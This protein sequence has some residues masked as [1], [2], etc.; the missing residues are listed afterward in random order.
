MA[1]DGI[2]LHHLQKEILQKAQNAKVDKIYQ[3]NREE[4]VLSLRTRYDTYKLLFSARANS[5]RVHFTT[6]TIENPK[7]P[8]MFCMLLRKR[9]TSAK[10]VQI[11]QNDLERVL[12]FDFDAYNELGDLIR[13]TLVCEIMG[14]YSNVIFLDGEEKIIDS[15]KRVDEEMTSERLVLP[16]LPYRL[17]P[18][19]NKLSLLCHQP[20]EVLSVM[21]SSVKN[22]ELVNLLLDT[23]Q[24]VSPVVCRELEHRIG[25]GSSKLIRELSPLQERALLQELE[26]LKQ[27]AEQVN[28]TPCMI[29]DPVT[30]KPM[31]FS[32][33]PIGQYGDFAQISM[34]DSFS[35]LLDSFYRERDRIERMK[36]KTQGLH[37]ILA[38][39]AE[40]LS[41]KINLQQG[42]LQRCT[43]REHLKICGDL[44]SANLYQ[45]QKGESTVSLCNFYEEEQPQ[46]TISLDPLLTPSQ[47]AQKYYKEYRKAKTAEEKLN[48]QIAMA[49][50]ELEYID[51]VQEALSRA[52]TEHDLT[53]IRQELTEQGYIKQLRQNKNR[54]N[55]EAEPMAPM[56][57]TSSDGFQILVGRNNR[58]NDK[59][60]MKQANNHDIWLHVKDH[61]GSHTVIVSDRKTVSQ[62]AILEAAQI[63]AYFSRCKDS[64]QVPVDYT[65]IRNVSK[66][67]GAKPGMVIYV[68]Y[69]TVYVTPNNPKVQMEQ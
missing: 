46:I 51:S 41:R 9:L 56:Q 68:N 24:G 59:L 5:A 37:R 35:V 26:Q 53:E 14:R 65:Q 7:Q 43:Q 66:P 39:A 32:F 22:R 38:T 20:E 31:D 54:K 36:V 6:E 15:L 28:G 12:F 21:K 23:L 3:P 44:I 49:K 34:P 64:A 19:Q 4:L 10:L 52:A 11:R 40:R 25:A 63:A 30:K 29:I 27:L 48:E 60:T 61:P 1:L 62:T 33:F 67:N 69:K 16:G 47:N 58:Q 50:T 2:F 45:I 8:P 42:E 13:L 17:P 18:P 55:K 57:F